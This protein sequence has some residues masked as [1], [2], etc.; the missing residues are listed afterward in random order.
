[1]AN[2]YRSIFFEGVVYYIKN[3][4][5]IDSYEHTNRERYKNQSIFVA[6]TDCYVYIVPYVEEE[7]Y[8]F[9]KTIIP[10]REAKKKYME[11]EDG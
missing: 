1:M 3:G 2:Q 7:N 10:D 6:L 5:L 4:G 8:Y 9:L 11:N